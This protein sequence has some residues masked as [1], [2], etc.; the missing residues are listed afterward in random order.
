VAGYNGDNIPAATAQLSDP[1]AVVIDAGGNLIIAD[2]QNRRIR[3]IDLNGTITTIAGTGIEGF[4][5]DGGPA[6]SAMLGRDTLA[7]DSAGNIFSPTRRSTAYAKSCRRNHQHYCRTGSR[8]IRRRWA[9]TG[10]LRLPMVSPL[11]AAVVF[12]SRLGQSRHPENKCLRRDT[13]GG[14]Q[15][16]RFSG[17]SSWPLRPS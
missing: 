14:R 4:S 2:A 3:K 17:G 12:I 7:I 8:A 11:M 13:G 16:R 15:N 9:A 6:T 10:N 5:G 1:E